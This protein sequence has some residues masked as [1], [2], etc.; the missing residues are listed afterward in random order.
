MQPNRPQN[1]RVDNHSHS[2]STPA[3]NDSRR[4]LAPY[5]RKAGNL[6]AAVG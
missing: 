4:T 5:R 2:P 3:V 6:E 1:R